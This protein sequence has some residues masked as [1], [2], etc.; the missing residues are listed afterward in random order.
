MK[1]QEEVCENMATEDNVTVYTITFDANGGIDNATQTL[2]E[3]CAGNGGYHEHVET[4]SRRTTRSHRGRYDTRK[5]SNIYALWW[6]PFA[7]SHRCANVSPSATWY[8][9]SPLPT[10]PL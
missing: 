2:Y 5:K 7:T 6:F 3:G 8:T 9:F 1:Q 4:S 10:C